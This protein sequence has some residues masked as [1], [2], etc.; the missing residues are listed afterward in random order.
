MNKENSRR[1]TLSVASAPHIGTSNS[2]GGMML[3]VLF[4]LVPALC[5]SVYFFG[6]R[7]LLLVCVT[8][9]SCVLS[10]YLYRRLR[11]LPGSVGDL[12]AAVTGGLL[13][14]SL[15]VTTPW[16]LAALAGGFAIVLVKQIFGG[17]GKNFL[18]P[19]L[20][21]RLCLFSFPVVMNTFG[22]TGVEHWVPVG[23]VDTVS[24]P[25]PLSLLHSGSLPQG[26]S[27]KEMLLGQR[28]GSLGEIAAFAL[29]LGGLY[30]VA[31]GVIRLRIP[32]CFL[33]TVAVLTFLF[34]QG[35][36]DAF[37]WM[38]YE[39]LSGGLMLGAIF[40]ATDPVTSPITPM[41]QVLYGIGCGV[42][43]VLLRYFGPYPEGVCGAILGMNM[44]VW[45][46]DKVGVPHRFG[47]TL[48][49]QK[50]QEVAQ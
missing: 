36:N 29:I 30:L 19:A 7:A 9:A 38:S 2:V 39:L 26:I 41:G 37:Q 21:G 15:P 22:A 35:G 24:A 27:L 17:L 45:A 49:P 23:V 6:P 1:R 8:V 11:H 12:S 43:T 3:D 25:T 50:N 46:L 32:L 14:M 5:V 34:P 28:G 10:E 47:T 13:A 44:L 20:L 42:L 31:R 4:A 18:N 48:M 40:M 16:Y 33:G